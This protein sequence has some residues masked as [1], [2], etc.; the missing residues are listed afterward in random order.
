MNTQDALVK[1]SHAT[2]DAVGAVL[3]SFCGDDTVTTGSVALVPRGANALT[4]LR[5][6]IVAV[7]VSYVDGVTGGNLFAMTL[8]GAR[9]VAA[10]VTGGAEVDAIDGG[11]SEGALA[12]LD[13]VTG[14]MMAAAAAATGELLGTIVEIAP[15]RHRLLKTTEAALDDPDQNVHV[16][17]VA[18]EIGGEECRLV[19]LVPKS[20]PI[21]MASANETQHEDAAPSPA[22]VLVAA[23]PHDPAVAEAI[24]GVNLRVWA[25]LGRTQMVTRDAVSL[26]PGAVVDLDRAVDDPV[27]LYVN[28]CRFGT[29]RLTVDADEQWVV[30]IVGLEPRETLTF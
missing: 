23:A 6:P 15:P 26:A 30:E 27:D 2:A 21:R 10:A 25:E 9:T 11:L 14:K 19:Q 7:D 29:G 1:L 3:R 18:F 12:A 28:G 17:S 8:D 20:F 24:R 22:P 4:M 13:D 16:T 5:P